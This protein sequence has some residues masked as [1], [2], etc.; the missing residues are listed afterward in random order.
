M[1]WYNSH[2]DYVDLNPNLDIDGVAVIGVGNVAMD[3]ARILAKNVSELEKT[4][5]SDHALAEL[6][7]SGVKNIYVLGRRGPAQAKFTNAEIREFGGLEGACATVSAAD[8]ELDPHS[9]ATVEQ[10]RFAKKNLEILDSFA[11]CV[12]GEK[13]CKVH[14][15][16]LTSPKE[17]KGTDGAVSG[18]VVER[19][20]LVSTD[21]GYLNAEG[22]G[23][24]EELNVGMVL[25]SVGYKGIALPGVPYDERKGTIPN[26][27]GRVL[28]T[29]TGG[30][31]PGAYVVGWAKRGPS[32][33]VGTNKKDAEETVAFMLE[34][35]PNLRRANVAHPSPKVVAEILKERGVEFVSFDEWQKINAIE[36]ER[37]Q[38]DGRPRNKFNT[39]EDMRAAL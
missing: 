36:I 29:E 10:N 2:P 1:A 15:K 13:K 12:D 35:V 7:E 4:D 28:N 20:K 9:K 32:G 39:V 24:L 30:P 38:K 16:F 21:D 18:I 17:I 27:N 14:F 6:A 34:D 33:V 22:T 19:N 11:K 23:E 3:V 31:L 5:I 26:D 25:R 37:G 8:L